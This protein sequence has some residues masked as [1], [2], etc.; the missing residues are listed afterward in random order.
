MNQSGIT[1]I[2]L[3][4]GKSVRMGVEKGLVRFGGRHLIEHSIRVLEEVCDEILISEN[5]NA[6]DFLGYKVIPDIHKNS[7]PMG[8]IFSAL[9]HS[10]TDLNL[11]LSCD[12][13]FISKDLFLAL[14]EN[15]K[16][17]DVAV[18]WH[19]E[20]KYEPM[21]AVYHKNVLPVFEHFIQNKNFKIPSAFKI[22]RVGKLLISEKQSFYNPQLF[23]NLN[24]KAE[25]EE[26][27]QLWEKNLPQWNNLLLIAGTGKNV[28]KTTL[29]RK[30]IKNVSKTQLVIGL[31]ISPHKHT[32]SKEAQQK[33][34]HPH[35]SIYEEFDKEGTKDSSR[36]L[37]AGASRVFYVEAEDRFIGHAIEKLKADFGKNTPIVCESG[38]LRNFV[39]P[40]LFLICRNKK[41]PEQEKHQPLIEKADQILKFKRKKNKF[42]FDISR[43]KFE[44]GKWQII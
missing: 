13:P 29:A 25:L 2:I 33:Y 28:G 8:G 1:G 12:M 34:I 5:T 10:K 19:G 32:E 35:F 37:K 38:G 18:P 26:A 11:V 17:K 30:L 4:G 20:E 27:E 15:A 22:L 14:I 40:S 43:L 7:G 3:A 36:M 23:K 44:N 9:K 6:Y 16:G 31:K 39:K 21:C 24:T 41:N 42:N